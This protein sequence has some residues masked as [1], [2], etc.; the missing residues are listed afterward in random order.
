[1]SDPTPEEQ[2]L[3]QK[4]RDWMRAESNA[5][6][7]TRHVTEPAPESAPETETEPSAETAA[8]S[9][10]RAELDAAVAAAVAK[11]TAVGVVTPPTGTS[12][13][14]PSAREASSRPDFSR[15]SHS[16]IAKQYREKVLPD[17]QAGREKVEV[18]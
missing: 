17:I 18:V 7:E 9:F 12:K 15:M 4:F 14:A 16:E 1:M 8:E 13:I 6:D 10:T 3:F 11:A 5:S 2:T